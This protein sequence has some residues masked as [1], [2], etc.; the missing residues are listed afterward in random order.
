MKIESLNNNFDIKSQIDTDKI[1]Q[2]ALDNC[3]VGE[4]EGF[5]AEFL[6]SNPEGFPEDILDEMSEEEVFETKECQE[7]VRNVFEDRLNE[8]I[9]VYTYNVILYDG[10]LTIYR[11]MTFDEVKNW[12]FLGDYLDHLRVQ[13]K[14]L[15]IYWSYDT[16]KAEAHW[17]DGG[18]EYLLQS[19]VNAR[20]VDWESTLT[21]NLHPT[22]G[23]E[24]A[25]VRLYKGTPLYIEAVW[26]NGV[27]VE[28][29]KEIARKK[30]LASDL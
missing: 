11:A 10:T 27:E 20:Y 18:V 16:D 14:H 26:K 23:Y 28:V 2:A 29:P 22:I 25:E 4:A 19:R 8:L 3:D 30:F 1:I 13:G 12:G 9:D 7:W 17:G 6:W 24:E 5:V 15:G 21:M